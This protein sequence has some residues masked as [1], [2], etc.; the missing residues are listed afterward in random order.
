MA[1]TGEEP[2]RGRGSGLDT[3]VP[4]HVIR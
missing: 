2:L 3:L 4:G 1:I